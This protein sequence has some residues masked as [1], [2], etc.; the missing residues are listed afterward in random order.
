MNYK[1]GELKTKYTRPEE[2]LKDDA[3]SFVV[4]LL[5][6]HV[7]L[8]GGALGGMFAGVPEAEIQRGEKML[9]AAHAERSPDARLGQELQAIAERQHAPNFIVLPPEFNA[10]RA[11]ET[12]WPPAALPPGVDSVLRC[13]VVD[14][15]FIG[16]RGVN[17]PM[18]FALNVELQVRRATD[19]AV[20]YSRELDYRGARRR[21]T[22]WAE[23]DAR[24]FR[25][26]M[27]RASK[28][29]A[30][31]IAEQLAAP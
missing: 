31:V 17:P 26:E 2:E 6:G 22:A 23:E 24:R 27:T 10:S 8:F 18:T 20:L 25:H 4:S 11:G 13:R 21:F 16:R 29:L 1:T 5:V 28:I 30:T 3:G 14:Q 15:Q 7:A 12:N 9:R 19:G